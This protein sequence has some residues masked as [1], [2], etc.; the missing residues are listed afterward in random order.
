[1]TGFRTSQS[2]SPLSEF[3]PG[4]PIRFF[5]YLQNHHQPVNITP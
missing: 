1:M 5:E 4:A 3:I 2:R